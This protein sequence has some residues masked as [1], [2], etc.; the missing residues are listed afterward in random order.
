[1]SNVTSIIPKE[2]QA[3]EQLMEENNNLKQE[4][5]SRQNKVADLQCQIEQLNR[6]LHAHQSQIKSLREDLAAREPNHHHHHQLNL[7]SSSHTQQLGFSDSHF[8]GSTT[9]S[10]SSLSNSNNNNNNNTNNPVTKL[11]SVNVTNGSGGSPLARHPSSVSTNSSTINSMPVSENY[12]A[13]DDNGVAEARPATEKP[14]DYNVS[15]FMGLCL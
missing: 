3:K 10:L 12:A 9:H 8:N 13:S 1:M 5:E 14:T 4:S 7:S 11:G 2:F 6:E 15:L